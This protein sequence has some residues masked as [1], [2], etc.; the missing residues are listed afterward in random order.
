[1]SKEGCGINNTEVYKGIINNTEVYKGI[2]NNT[3]V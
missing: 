1:M 2:I 3:E